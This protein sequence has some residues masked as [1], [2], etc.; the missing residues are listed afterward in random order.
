MRRDFKLPADDEAFL[1]SRGHGWETVRENG[2]RWLLLENYQLPAGYNVT[3]ASIALRI[4]EMYP[5]VQIDMAYFLPHLARTDGQPINALTPLA[6]DGKQWQQ[7][8]RHRTGADAWQIG[9]D[10]VERHLLFTQAFLETE[11]RKR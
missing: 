5:D 1:D 2:T 4:Q 3:Q 10:N 6:I 8:S 9:V 11:L 7:W